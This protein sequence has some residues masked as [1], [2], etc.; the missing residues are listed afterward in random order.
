MNTVGVLNPAGRLPLAFR[1]LQPEPVSPTRLLVLLHGVGGDERNLAA[2]GAA[3]G[4]DTLVVLPRGPLEIG[5]GQYAWFRVTFAADGP[6]IVATEAD[7]SRRTLID[8]VAG[9]QR[10]HGIAPA[11]TVIAGFSQRSV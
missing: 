4:D 5:P 8:F 6:R 11:R 10:L 9:A 3:V 2:L 7:A 1:T